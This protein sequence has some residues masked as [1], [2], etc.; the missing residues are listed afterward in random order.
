MRSENYPTGKSPTF[1]EEARHTQLVRCAVQTIAE[2][3]L[4]QSSIAEIARRAGLTKTA[5]F[6][7]FSGRD[8]LIDAVVSA[9]LTGA[10]QFMSERADES[11]DPADQLRSYIGTNIE[12]IATHRAETRALVSIAMT[13]VDKAGRSRLRSDAW[14]YEQSLAPLEDILIRG[15]EQGTFGSFAP[16]TTAVTIRA[17][18]DAIGPQLSAIPDL[19]LDEYTRDLVGLFDRATERS[20]T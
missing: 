10:A 11:D 3:G 12:Y 19:D 16:R 18:I 4:P 8:E 17:A 9:V 13:H 1:I 7:H 14:R 2:I 20:R 6:Y 15:Q 5:V